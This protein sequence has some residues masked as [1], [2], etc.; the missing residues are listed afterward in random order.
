MNLLRSV[1]MAFSIFSRIPMPHM[2]WK[3]QHMRYMMASLPLVGAVIGFALWGW[4]A[5][6]SWLD[7]GKWLWASGLALVPVAVSGGI[8][9]DGFADTVDALASRDSVEKKREILKD[10]HIGAF[11]AITLCAYF[12]LY[13]ALCAELERAWQTVLLLG[14]VHCVSRISG[15]LA[16]LCLPSA[17]TEGLLDTAR[18][19]A[20]RISV[21]LLA[22]EAVVV[23]GAAVWTQPVSGA[24]VLFAGGLCFLYT[25]IMAKKQFGG[26]SGD[27]AGYLIQ[28]SELAMLAAVVLSQKGAAAW[29]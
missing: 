5:F 1:A 19:A 29:F 25:A 7:I 15:G 6:C 24:A 21:L 18:Q 9:L 23:I 20:G 16:I 28:L 17:K 13:T 10:P 27:L 2:A 22:A 11:A 14:L 4:T 12:L 8:H 26:M 3:K